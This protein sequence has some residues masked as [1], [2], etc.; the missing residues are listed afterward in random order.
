MI[1]RLHDTHGVPMADFARRHSRVHFIGIG[2]TG[3]S[4]IA[5]VLCTLGYQVSGSDM[6]DS[7]VTRRLAG[8]GATVHRGHGA[9]NV[10]GT[11]C[12]VVSSAIQPDNPE[13]LEARAQRIPVVPRAEMLAELMR[14]RRGVAVAGT[15]GKTTTTSLLAS[16]LAEGGL[17]PTFVIG[18]KLLAAGANARLG[19]GDWLVAEADESD[20]SFLR[21]NPLVAIVTN[22]D[23]DHLENYGGD[24]AR[25]QQAFSEFLHRLPFYGLAVLCIDDPEVA[26]LA[27][28]VSRHVMTYGFHADADVRADNVRQDGATMYFDL[29]LP[30]GSSTPMEL[31]MPGRHNVQNALAAAAVAWELGVQ[32]DAM[33]T[34]LAK[35]AGVGRR[36]NRL[37][38]LTTA[39]GA[40]VQLVDDYGHHPRELAAVFEAARGGWPE[41]RLVVAFQPHRYSRT[42]D[43]LDDFAGVLS[44]V[45]ALVLTEVYPAGEQP[46]PNADARALA[47]AI[48]ARG[49]ID[50]VVVNGPGDLRDVLP[51]ILED[52]DLLLVMGAGDIGHA[53]QSLAADG[54]PAAGEGA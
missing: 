30:D 21:L 8:L 34:A 43:L 7:A 5:E 19:G 1:R 44:D 35:F 39:R 47:R 50:P 53:S 9:A 15:H 24:F 13:L 4:G 31:A 17:D 29:V 40:R 49:R 46:L 18:G 20:G 38:E 32:P 14:F 33:R 10:L 37:A 42:R 36:F 28:T 45:D 11:D 41:R 23:V 27:G 2:G 6:A 48:R 54:F 16:V 12:V 52:G 3:M 22:I 51:D 26:A 25:V